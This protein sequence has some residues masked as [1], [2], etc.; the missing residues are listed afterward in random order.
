M[1][2]FMKDLIARNEALRLRLDELHRR[3]HDY[4]F[5]DP[6]VCDLIS[7][8]SVDIEMEISKNERAIREIE[9]AFAV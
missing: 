1:E 2:T 8:K 6:F 7:E 3:W 9:E 4:C 5:K